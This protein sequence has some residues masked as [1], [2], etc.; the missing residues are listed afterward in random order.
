MEPVMEPGSSIQIDVVA[1]GWLVH[2]T[3]QW[4][5]NY[6][7]HVE[8]SMVFQRMGNPREEGTLLHFIAQH[9]EPR[10]EKSCKA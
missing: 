9:F 8:V 1:N 7:T 3:P 4:Q 5:H 10:T 6:A 2:P